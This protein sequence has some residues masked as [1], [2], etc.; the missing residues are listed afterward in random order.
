LWE[1]WLEDQVI[2]ERLVTLLSLAAD[3]QLSGRRAQNRSGIGDWSGSYELVLYQGG[4]VNPSMAT[5]DE[6]VCPHI[7]FP[8]AHSLQAR[9]IP[10]TSYIIEPKALHLNCLGKS[11]LSSNVPAFSLHNRLPLSFGISLSPT[12]QKYLTKSFAMTM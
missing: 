8:D 6:W 2:Q 1:P 12:S 11:L 5:W 3:D 10:A 7:Q 4:G 9:H